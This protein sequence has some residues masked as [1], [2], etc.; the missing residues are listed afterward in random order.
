[1]RLTIRQFAYGAI[2]LYAHASVIPG[3]LL[4]DCAH[5]LA[6]TVS[7]Y[8]FRLGPFHSE[9]QDVVAYL[10]YCVPSF[11]G[12]ERRNISSDFASS[13]H[14]VELGMPLWY[15]NRQ[16]EGMAC[17]AQAAEIDKGFAKTPFF[18]QKQAQITSHRVLP[19]NLGE[20]YL[21]EALPESLDLWPTLLPEFQLSLVWLRF[22]VAEPRFQFHWFA[23]MDAVGDGY[24][25]RE[26]FRGL[27]PD[28]QNLYLFG[29]SPSSQ[30][31]LQAHIFEDDLDSARD[32]KSKI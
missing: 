29:R 10:N 22:L 15:D 11:V 25:C 16:A 27:G 32:P 18:K 23:L 7:L 3:I 21:N 2:A 9:Q 26:I 19:S 12:F 17:L 31:R 13:C 4:P 24:L 14:W 5:P 30:K 8:W 1:M 20:Y 28:A 6:A